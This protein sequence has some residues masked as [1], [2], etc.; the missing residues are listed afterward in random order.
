MKRYVLV[1]LTSGFL[2][3]CGSSQSVV[4]QMDRP[5]TVVARFQIL[6]GVQVPTEREMPLFIADRGR[7]RHEFRAYRMIS[8]NRIQ[9]LNIATSMDRITPA[10][11]AVIVPGNTP[12]S[13][14][15]DHIPGTVATW[16]NTALMVA[17]VAR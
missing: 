6:S 8:T 15:P 5:A 17:C 3:A 11:N 1:V 16:N 10:A 2:A 9:A 4:K 12:Q 13:A 14:K 7:K